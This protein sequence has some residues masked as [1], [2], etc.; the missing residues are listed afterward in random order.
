VGELRCVDFQK[1]TNHLPY[2]HQYLQRH[3]RATNLS[4]AMK[5]PNPSLESRYEIPAAFLAG[6]RATLGPIC[7][8]GR[9]L[10][11]RTSIF[12]GNAISTTQP[13][14]LHKHF[15]RGRSSDFLHKSSIHDSGAMNS[16]ESIL[17][18]VLGDSRYRLSEVVR[19]GESSQDNVIATCLRDDDI[20]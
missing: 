4:I 11:Q 6:Q 3:G 2:S 14:Q 17:L 10:S 1:E 9:E 19:T 16:N 12:S 5:E 20:R 7:T 13:R 15:S 8:A 18:K